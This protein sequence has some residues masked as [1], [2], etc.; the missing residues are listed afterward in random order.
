[1][2]ITFFLNWMGVMSNHWYEDNNISYTEETRYNSI[3][4]KEIT[5]KR[6]K[7]HYSIGRID[8]HGVPDEPY[9]ISYGVPLMKDTSWGKLGIYLGSL[10]LDYLPTVEDLFS[11]FEE[12]TQHKIEWFGGN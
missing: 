4:G 8:I 10:E 11:M 3:L 12:S 7:T 9:G 1:M 5:T 2:K 6:W